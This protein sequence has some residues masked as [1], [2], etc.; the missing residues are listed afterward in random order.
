MPALQ[1]PR[2]V[3]T[4][5]QVCRSSAQDAIQL[6]I[7]PNYLDRWQTQR[8][9]TGI[10]E[11]A[12]WDSPKAVADRDGIPSGVENYAGAEAVRRCVAKL[13]ERPSTRRIK[14]CAC[15]DLE[16][17]KI[18]RPTF[19]DE[20]DLVASVAVVVRPRVC[21]RPLCV[22]DDLHRGKVLE[23]LAR[24]LIVTTDP[25]DVGTEQMDEKSGVDDV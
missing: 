23:H 9:W 12:D 6:C 18:S 20:V 1:L 2:L 17:G 5:S 4:R 7:P 16:R 21:P 3:Y 19:Q 25:M 13:G 22:L 10:P 24:D 15:F 8:L 11:R 14:G